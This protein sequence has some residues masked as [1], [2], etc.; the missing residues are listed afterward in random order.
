MEQRTSFVGLGRVAALLKRLQA[1]FDTDMSMTLFLARHAAHG[2]LGKVLTGRGAGIR[3]SDQGRAQ[4]E[5]LAKRL[6]REEIELVH[7]SP[8]ERAMETS[9]IVARRLRVPIEIAPALDEIDFGEW[10][11]RSFEQLAQ[12]RRWTQW[13]GRRSEVSPPGGET[14]A[15]AVARAMIHVEKI[16]A[17]A[18]RRV[19]CIS[20]ADV[21][22]GIVADVLGLS[23]DNLLRFDIDPASLSALVIG[24]REMRLTVLNESC[25][26]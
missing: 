13:N 8:R 2:D 9:E 17:E 20:H 6:D 25:A 3:L 11:G 19:L 18:R 16:G 14:M 22:R 24:R 4:A 15:E 1:S 7:S 5:G 23:L 12:D 10:T 21:I 26:G